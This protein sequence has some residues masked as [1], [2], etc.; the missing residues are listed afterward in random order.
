MTGKPP[1]E[2]KLKILGVIQSGRTMRGT[3]LL[4]R[5]MVGSKALMDVWE[6]TMPKD[7]FSM[8]DIAKRNKLIL[9]FL[10]AANAEGVADNQAFEFFDR[11]RSEFTLANRS[12]MSKDQLP[13]IIYISNTSETNVAGIWCKNDYSVEHGVARGGAF[14]TASGM[15]KEKHILE[16][17]SDFTVIMYMLNHLAHAEHERK[18]AEGAERFSISSDVAP[19]IPCIGDYDSE[20]KKG[21]DFD[22]V[23][24]LAILRLEKLAQKARDHGHVITKD[25]A[26]GLQSWNFQ[27]NQFRLV[28]IV[29]DIQ[30]R[31][32]YFVAKK[33]GKIVKEPFVE[34]AEKNGLASNE[35][36]RKYLENI[37]EHESPENTAATE[38]IRRRRCCKS[39][40]CV[41]ARCGNKT[42]SGVIKVI[43]AYPSEKELE[44]TLKN[45]F[46]KSLKVSLHTGCGYAK[47][48]IAFDDMLEELNKAH[49]D[50]YKRD[51]VMK[52]WQ[53]LGA[54]VKGE[55]AEDD[56]LVKIAKG[57]SIIAPPA[58]KPV[59]GQLHLFAEAEEA[60]KKGKVQSEMAKIADWLGLAKSKGIF[61]K[62]FEGIE[63]NDGE[64]HS[65]FQRA[66][67]H[68]WDRKL[69]V[70]DITNGFYMSPVRSVK[71]FLKSNGLDYDT[72]NERFEY[73]VLEQMGREIKA[74]V[75]KLK[76]T[77][78]NGKS[79]EV[80]IESLKNSGVYRIPES[81]DRINAEVMDRE[82]FFRI[83]KEGNQEYR[84]KDALAA[85]HQR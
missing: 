58:P 22:A 5:T 49:K 77:L 71:S 45:Q 67:K 24:R 57:W 3:S 2:Q 8:K 62:L 40:F 18:R 66:V 76:K 70:G 11:K 50:P 42:A 74:T 48:A 60:E 43:G 51:F 26:T 33:G 13:G 72:S 38:L 63:F 52:V 69:M 85:R 41:D 68:M 4:G 20:E 25:K 65:D 31:K 47:T 23:A 55:F 75:D 19:Y 53:S 80:V 14:G 64:T 21:L 36:S 30:T 56:A 15:R 39:I 81:L 7:I 37:M 10:D 46:S 44:R 29:H 28:P 32:L 78:R 82:M 17:A 61:L 83:D 16:E 9:S 34:F 35:I 59:E 27:G 84:K 79:V 73:L 1:E 12:D 6:K 54:M